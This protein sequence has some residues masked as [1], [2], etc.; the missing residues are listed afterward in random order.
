MA[1]VATEPNVGLKR[2]L[3]LLQEAA[4][5]LGRDD[6]LQVIVRSLGEALAVRWAF[7]SE[8]VPDDPSQAR[9]VAFCQDGTLLDNMAYPLAGTPCADVYDRS[10]CLV[11]EGA[12]EA[13]PE[14]VML[15]DMGIES[16]LGLP[17]VDDAGR[18][19]GHL[20]VMH[21]RPLPAALLDEPLFRIFVAQA[22]SEFARRGAEAEKHRVE[23]KLM[24]SERR[25]SLGLLAGTIAHDLNNL[26]VGITANVGLAE[27]ELD[28]DSAARPFLQAIEKTG[29]RAAELA[30]QMLAYSGRGRFEV[31]PVDLGDIVRQTGD[32]LRPSL[33]RTA[34]VTYVVSD[35]LPPVQADPTQ[36]RQLVMNLVIN[37]VD[38]MEGRPGRVT[39]HV[40]LGRIDLD[41][42]RTQVVAREAASGPCVSLEVSDEGTGMD[43]ETLARIFDPFFTTKAKG[44]GLGLAAVVGIVQGHKGV[45][46]VGSRLGHGTTFTVQLPVSEQPVPA[47]RVVADRGVL[48]PGVRALVVDDEPAVRN[49]LAA[50][51]GRNG[52]QVVEAAD[53]AQGLTL[54]QATTEAFDV[55]LIDLSMPRVG[56]DEVQ[57]HAGHGLVGQVAAVAVWT[58]EDRMNA[59]TTNS[60]PRLAPR[61][62][63]RRHP[64][65]EPTERIYL[66]IAFSASNIALTRSHSL[67]RQTSALVRTVSPSAKAPTP[68]MSMNWSMK[69]LQSTVVPASVLWRATTPP[70]V[71][72]MS[73]PIRL[74]TLTTSLSP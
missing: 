8:L 7:V 45:L 14:D 1:F 10:A 37:A 46:R 20:G 58:A 24:E 42:P 16:Y 66:P 38:A 21:D 70:S 32:L 12:Q 5:A 9:T 71:I 48:P 65:P 54:L 26:L 43:D 28:G 52:V 23:R 34:E 31:G 15:Q 49:A 33:P 27:L 36:L 25:E 56:G 64:A 55:V 69:S 2:Q 11:T 57:D 40:G 60:D 41:E 19:L 39:I 53:G 74:R 59:V 6:Y 29:R 68:A 18:A 44:N 22:G 13:Y 3:A 51:L 72:S 67:W 61:P 63:A 30:Q 47:A 17:F 62:D 73:A 4:E 35:G 50:V